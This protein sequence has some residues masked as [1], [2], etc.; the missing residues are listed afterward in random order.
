M[1]SCGGSGTSDASHPTTTAHQ[2][3]TT[4]TL[5]GHPST[6]TVPPTDAAIL[7]AYRAEWSAFEH[8]EADANPLD[9]LLKATMVDP[10]LHQVEGYLVADN[11]EGIVGR[12]PITLDPK[13]AS[14]TAT[15]ATV[16]D[17]SYSKAYLYYKRS[18]KEVPPITGPERIG[19]KAT[20]VL[21]GSTWK[22][23]SQVLTEGSCPAG[24]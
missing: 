24:Y 18:G 12:G 21:N 13:I 4:S 7:A 17:C 23:K 20:L 19:V 8:A 6:T 11:Q 9:P 1:T 14:A 2:S 15:S 10:L 3:T 5:P 22:V 16:S